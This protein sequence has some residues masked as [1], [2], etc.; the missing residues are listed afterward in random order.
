M[1]ALLF[2]RRDRRSRMLELTPTPSMPRTKTWRDERRTLDAFKAYR[3]TPVKGSEVARAAA[4]PGAHVN[5]VL[6]HLFKLDKIR[7]SDPELL[8]SH[9]AQFQSVSWVLTDA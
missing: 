5:A 4:I 3:G 1:C 2:Y 6:R 8:S 7:P 9:K